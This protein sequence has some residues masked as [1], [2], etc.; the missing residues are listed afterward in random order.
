MP[1]ITKI[2]VNRQQ[3]NNYDIEFDQKDWFQTI[4]ICKDTLIRF[5][6][7]KGMELDENQLQQIVFEDEVQKGFNRAISYLSHSMR[8]VKQVKDHLSEK[9]FPSYVVEEV[10]DRLKQK[11]YV[12]DKDFARS[13]IQT[14]IK[15]TDKGPIAV[16]KLLQDKGIDEQTI[17]EEITL[18]SL[19]IQ[20]EKARRLS[21][22]WVKRKQGLSVSLLKEQLYVMLKRKGYEDEA[23]QE[24]VYE[25]L[26]SLD[27]AH[28]LAAIKIQG[29]KALKKYAKV[30]PEERKWKIKQF[31]YRK[32]FS[33]ELIH[34]YVENLQELE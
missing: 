34:R 29:E 27:E 21:L 5:R 28:N 30:P 22:K 8:S 1:V 12:N 16:K 4:T 24:V 2:A 11:G 13:F 20:L 33:S 32:G 17:E 3:P 7:S 25:T 26:Q 19:D 6:L 18:F 23:I 31:L 10:I 15:T 9:G 14:Y